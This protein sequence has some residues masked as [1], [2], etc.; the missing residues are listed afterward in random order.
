MVSNPHASYLYHGFTLDRAGDDDPQFSVNTPMGPISGPGQ[1]LAILMN[2]VPYR[3]QNPANDFMLD[4]D[5]AVPGP[6]VGQGFGNGGGDT[7]YRLR[8]GIE[9][10]LITDINNPAASAVAQSEIPAMWD[11]VSADPSGRAEFNHVPG[12]AS[13]LYLDGHV[14]FERYPGKFPAS[15]KASAI[16]PLMYAN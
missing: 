4:E 10:F 8:Q 5:I 13:V 11:I 14:V 1:V 6:M 16:I 9:R 7:V 12:G 2:I 15:R 3:D